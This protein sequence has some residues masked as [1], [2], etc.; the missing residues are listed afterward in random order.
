MTPTAYM[1]FFGRD[2]FSEV[3]GLSDL[4]AMAYV[5]ALWHYWSRTQCGGLPN[6]CALLRKV[7][8]VEREDWEIVSE[9]IF[10]N[11]Q[12]FTLDSDGLWQHDR[13]LA[14]WREVKEKYD[15]RMR[16]TAAA[17]EARRKR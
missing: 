15:K 3:D 2:I 6:D 10:D 7:C 1:P 4:V 11:E 9:T 5:R 12:F 16:Q 14:A 17:N 13:T 8:R